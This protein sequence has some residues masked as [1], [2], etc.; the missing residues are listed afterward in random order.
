MACLNMNIRITNI[1]F[2]LET[3]NN[4]KMLNHK[5]TANYRQLFSCVTVLINYVSWPPA[6]ILMYEYLGHVLKLCTRKTRGN[7]ISC[8]KQGVPP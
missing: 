8:K 4:F 7:S 3:N 6:N 2:L 5:K 1:F